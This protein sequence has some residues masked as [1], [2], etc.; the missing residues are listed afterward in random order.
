MSAAPVFV[1]SSGRAGSSMIAQALRVHPRVLALHEPHPRLRR[2]AY[3]AWSGKRDAR[4]LRARLE[5]KRVSLVEQTLANGFVYLESAHYCSH[6][7]VPL[8]E[9]FPDAKFVFLHRDGREFVCSGLERAWYR[10]KEESALAHGVKF[11]R[12]RL[13]LD[14]GKAGW[15]HRLA[16]PKQLRTRAERIA[17]LWAEINRSIERGLA[18]V[19]ERDVFRL[20][21]AA[22]SLDSLRALTQFIGV[23]ADEP[24]LREM[25]AVAVERPN[26]TRSRTVP[27]FEH[28]PLEQQQQF[29]RIAGPMMK[30]LGYPSSPPDPAPTRIAGL[31]SLRPSASDP[32][33]GASRA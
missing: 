29:F 25:M 16:P 20:P 24:I 7:I 12:D 13:R 18:A 30:Q 33:A 26:Q 19:P 14:L 6:L 21:L 27:A 1:V 17:W 3:W 5:L 10:G 23:D 8:R 28:W 32:E 11:A 31:D 22:L 15:D 9:L 4:W 2:E